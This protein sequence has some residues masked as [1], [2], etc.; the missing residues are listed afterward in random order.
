MREVAIDGRRSTD[1]MG[2]KAMIPDKH[3]TST[4]AASPPFHEHLTRSVRELRG[5]LIELLL[6][7][8]A[9][10]TTPQVTARDFGLD[11]TLAWKVAKLIDA[12]DPS[13]AVQHIPG[14][15][16]MKILLKAM[17]RAG[18]PAPVTTAVQD[19]MS[20]FDRMVEIHTGDRA[21]LDLA[22]GA[23]AG[24]PDQSDRLEAARKL[25]FQ[26]NSATW[27]IQARVRL[28]SYF[29]A[30]NADD[31]EMIDSAI[32]GGLV[33]CRRLRPDVAWPVFQS[34]TYNDDGTDLTARVE[35]IDPDA[36]PGD[37]PPLMGR[38]CTDPRPLLRGIEVPGGTL[39][40]LAEGPVGNMG[41]VS[42]IFGWYTRRFASIRRDEHNTFGEHPTRQY[43]PVES[44]I[45]DLY[46]HRDL[47]V[48][49]PPEAAVYSRLAGGV[50][51]PESGRDRD[52]IPM[53]ERVIELGAEPPIV[54][55]PLVP[56]YP[57]MVDSVHARLG[58]RQSEFV[59][60]RLVVRYPP[61]PSLI[62]LRYP[63]LD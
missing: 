15:P 47:A 63:L 44:A 54:S 16:G 20:G 21:T 46:V 9:D 8:G 12:T 14:K 2:E 39:Y 10:P 42:C 35:P 45:C 5:S 18:A 13:V 48:Q 7:V 37:G 61:I 17:E 41:T 28:A 55:T 11:K 57:D 29:I 53:G 31:P 32:V 51:Y 34:Q 52:L 50:E 60:Y 1:R 25:A 22:L 56:G 24:A 6:S 27:G 38:F 4:A 33:D 49:M 40:E 59:G 26:G 43:T 19:A 23:M 30:P 3:L 62:V 58:W 36:P